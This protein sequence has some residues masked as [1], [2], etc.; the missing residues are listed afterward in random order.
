MITFLFVDSERVWR[1]GQDQ[2]MNLLVGLIGR[3]HEIHL[4]CHP[5]TLLDERARV[6]GVKVH[7]VSFRRLGRFAVFFR[8]LSIL[9]GVGPDILA[10]N[11]PKPILLG[12]LASRFA[13][14][15]TRVIFRRVNFPLRHNPV[16]RLKYSWGISCIVAISESISTQLQAGGVPASRIRTVYEG[17]DLALFTPRQRPVWRRPG[18]PRIIGTVAHLSE[19]KGLRYLVEAAAHIRDV[20]SR[21]RFVIVGEGRCRR[22]ARNAFPFAS[23]VPRCEGLPNRPHIRGHRRS[24]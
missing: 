13:S 17:M 7:P 18:H 19:E 10:F 11:T 23:A 6:A 15:R 24:P 1:G 3:G 12:N 20:R 5:R 9:R 21:M 14:V 4:I 2:L 22:A 8:L 16:T